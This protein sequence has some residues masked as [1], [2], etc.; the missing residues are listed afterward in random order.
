VVLAFVLADILVVADSLWWHAMA[1]SSRDPTWRRLPQFFVNVWNE[2]VEHSS[3]DVLQLALA[4]SQASLLA[5]WACLGRRRWALRWSAATAGIGYCVTVLAAG[6]ASEYQPT[7]GELLF[8]TQAM[9]IV[10]VALGMRIC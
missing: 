9:T 8:V 3:V 2:S 1:G 10:V 6:A 4:S 5:L 7:Q